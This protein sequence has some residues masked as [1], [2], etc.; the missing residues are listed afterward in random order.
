MLFARSDKFPT[1]EV[2]GSVLAAAAEDGPTLDTAL[3]VA[4]LDSKGLYRMQHHGQCVIWVP[5]GA[6]FL[7]NRRLVCVY[8]E[9]GGHRGVDATMAR[10]E[11]RC[12]WDRGKTLPQFTV[13][14]YVLV[15]WV[16]R[17]GKCRKLLSP[18]TG[19]WRVANDD[20]EHVYAVQQLVTAKLRD[21]HVARMRF[22]ADDKVE[23]TGELLKVSNNLRTRASTTS[24]ASRASSGLQAATS[25]L[26][27]WPGKDWRRRRAP[28]RR[29]RAC[30]TTH[31]PCKK[32]SR[33]CG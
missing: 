29:C 9:G 3:E 1:K 4:S 13:V 30:S 5:G 18:W 28:G 31:R 23:I 33:R 6:D 19:A 2:V 8:Q 17:Q 22:Y 11:R 27:R 20:K 7:K 10:L 24:G 14:D 32:G 15:A 12:V 21:D 16:F 26:S 25:A